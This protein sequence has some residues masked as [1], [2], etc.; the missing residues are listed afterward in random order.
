M[1]N[2]RKVTTRQQLYEDNLFR[3]AVKL[4]AR[5]EGENL[6]KENQELGPDAVGV[7]PEK[8]EEFRNRLERLLL[9]KKR[10]ENRFA[11]VRILQKVAVI[12][13]VIIATVTVTIFSVEA[14][15][16]RVLNLFMEIKPEYTEFRLEEE[17]QSE[18]AARSV[19]WTDAYVP[20]YVPEGYR[21]E[22]AENGSDMKTIVFINDEEK[23]IH[24]SQFSE[25]VSLNYDTENASMEDVTVNGNAG[26]LIVK[27]DNYSVIWQQANS[28]FV[29]MTQINEEETL[30]IAE[31]ITFNKF[32]K[33][34]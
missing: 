18:G 17:D 22:S 7:S 8:Q 15:R 28:I 30:K 4:A 24:Y 32:N 1:A 34:S 16:V 23:I 11:A 13:L 5:I 20:A 29:V 31:S 19:D 2:D 25:N 14:F 33:K 10:R 6:L 21:V 12:A 3:E 27:G 9:N 26:T